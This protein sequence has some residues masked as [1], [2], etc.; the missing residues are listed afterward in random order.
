LPLG[1]LQKCQKSNSQIQDQGRE[2]GQG[3]RSS[4]TTPGD[5]PRDP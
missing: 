5:S 2:V 3:I 1:G 4:E